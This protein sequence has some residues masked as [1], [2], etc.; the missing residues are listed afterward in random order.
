[1]SHHWPSPPEPTACLIPRPSS[2]PKGGT[3]I[4]ADVL[5]PEAH[6]ARVCDPDGYRPRACAR[7][8]HAVLHVHDY[9]CRT[10]QRDRPSGG[11]TPIVIVRHVCA[12]V[13]C[14]AIWQTLPA[15]LPRHLWHPWRV[16]E[17]TSFGDA[18][19]A[20]RRDVPAR[21]RARWSKRLGSAA[22]ALLQ[23]FAVEIGTGIDAVAIVAGPL[24][25]RAGLVAAYARASAVA[26]GRRLLKVAAVVHAIE[27]TARLM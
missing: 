6:A 19:V 15:F 22:L 3:L 14:G 25:T 2:T 16:V 5:T 24:V 18:P 11:A 8:G 26:A 21:T 4:A 23:L 10:A 27:R 7:C 12:N 20:D 9:R 1:M 13:A 17:A